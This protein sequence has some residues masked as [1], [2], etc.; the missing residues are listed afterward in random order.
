MSCSITFSIGPRAKID[1]W[2]NKYS[3]LDNIG[4]YAKRWTYGY[5]FV[6]LWFA[7]I[8]TKPE[9]D[10]IIREVSGFNQWIELQ[11]D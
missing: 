7:I 5:R 8:I 10:E 9:Y 11:D 2:N 6:F 3:F 1:P 4:I